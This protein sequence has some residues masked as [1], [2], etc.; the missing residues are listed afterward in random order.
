M[1]EQSIEKTLQ[2][3]ERV[4]WKAY[5][6]ADSPQELRALMGESSNE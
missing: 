3:R 2:D 5:R 4:F 6:I 1:T